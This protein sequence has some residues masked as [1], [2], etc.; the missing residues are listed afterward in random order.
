MVCGRETARARR[1]L[2]YELAIP[3]IDRVSRPEVCSQ[4]RAQASRPTA[5]ARSRRRAGRRGRRCRTRGSGSSRADR[6]GRR[7]R[8]GRRQLLEHRGAL[9]VGDA[10][11]VLE[12]RLGVRR[13]RCRRPGGST[14]TGRRTEP[15]SLRTTPNSVHSGYWVASLQHRCAMYS[16][17]DSF[18]HRSSHQR[19][20]T[21]SPNH[22]CAISWATRPGPARRARRRWPAPR[23]MNWSRSVTQPGFS[24]APA[25]KSGTKAWWYSPNG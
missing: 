3:A 17:N 1:R 18:S 14:A 8:R 22:M 10:V 13:R 11:E 2:P 19:M 15:Q 7:R 16:A 21:R 24:I 9:G 20:V 12:R 25:L 4:S 5:P 23:K 6:R